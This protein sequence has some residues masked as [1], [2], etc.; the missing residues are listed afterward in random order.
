MAFIFELAEQV[1]IKQ[2]RRSGEVVAR[3]EYSEGQPESYC[4]RFINGVGDV[5]SEWFGATQLVTDEPF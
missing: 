1:I 5:Q 2:N 3:A 4:V